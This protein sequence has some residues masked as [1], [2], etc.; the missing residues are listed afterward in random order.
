MGSESLNPRGGSGG[1]PCNGCMNA[2]EAAN[3]LG[4]PNRAPARE[5]EQLG[6][7]RKRR[8]TWNQVQ[9]VV[10]SQAHIELGLANPSVPHLAG[11]ALRALTNG[12]LARKE[13]RAKWSAIVS[14]SLGDLDRRGLL[15]AARCPGLGHH[16]LGRYSTLILDWVEVLEEQAHRLRK[17]A[18]QI[19]LGA[20][21]LRLGSLEVQIWIE[22]AGGQTDL[23]EASDVPLH[24]V[25][26]SIAKTTGL[27]VHS[28]LGPN[29]L[30]AN[31]PGPDLDLQECLEKLGEPLAGL[32]CRP[33]EVTL[34]LHYRLKAGVL[35]VLL[36]TAG[37]VFAVPAMQS[38]AE[39]IAASASEVTVEAL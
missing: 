13:A 14:D 21:D 26:A 20:I 8:Y 6:L 37:R 23:G 19:E 38:I 22:D 3:W 24:L 17:A 5:L 36:E 34:H 35:G 29:F 31:V 15:A 18:A 28:L 39:H 12:T 30:R 25:K 11:A 9:A 2:G 33:V 16:S 4:L 10:G 1:S 27:Q 32:Y 7:A